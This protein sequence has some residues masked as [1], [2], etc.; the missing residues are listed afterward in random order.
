MF[1]KGAGCHPA[2]SGL[3]DPA[4][5]VL[6]GAGMDQLTVDGS[7][8]FPGPQCPLAHACWQAGG[9]PT[10]DCATSEDA[11]S[12]GPQP[13]A[14]LLFGG[15]Q[16]RALL[17]RRWAQGSQGEPLQARPA[18]GARF[19]I[20]I[21]PRWESVLAKPRRHSQ[22]SSCMSQSLWAT[23]AL[24]DVCH[25]SPQCRVFTLWKDKGNAST[26]WR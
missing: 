3:S 8:H 11:G 4:V 22:N 2:Q 23:R 20:F 13:Q 12:L 9:A 24:P 1:Q 10:P 7:P 6:L 19:M 14:P 17:W 16:V 21:L 5:G 26:V 15:E 18:R 25:L